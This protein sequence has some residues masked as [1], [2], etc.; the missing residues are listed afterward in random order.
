MSIADYQYPLPDEK[1]ARFP[2]PKR[3]ESKL[4]IYRQG[5]I[6]ERNYHQ[7]PNFIPANALLIL[8]DTRVV[9]ARLYM[10]TSGG[11]TVEVFC[12]EPGAGYADISSAMLTPGK[13]QWLCLIGGAKK[14]KEGILSLT[15]RQGDSNINLQAR[16]L[17]RKEG[18]F[19]L[20]LSWMP[21]SVSF[22]EMLSIVG[23]LP[24]PPYLN[25]AADPEDYERYQTVFAQHQGSVAA[26][27]AG[28]HFTNELLQNLKN[29]S[30]TNAFITLHV[31]AGTFMPVKTEKIGDHE[32]HREYI[33]VSIDFLQTLQQHLPKP[34]ITV[35]TT[36][37][38]TLESIYWLGSKLIQN[39]GVL[40][41]ELQVHQWDPYQPGNQTATPLAAIHALLSWMQQHQLQHLMAT[42]Q[43]MIAP[44]YPF[45]FTDALITN[46]HQPG[47]TLLLLVSALVGDDWRKIYEYALNHS[48]RFLSYGDGSLLWRTNNQ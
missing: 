40:P 29:K 37:M 4:L 11:Q 43:L 12:L 5:E 44:G 13:V 42:T 48:F 1:I 28:L 41:G 15:Y 7:L 34:V 20:E 26:P 2:L 14:W 8:N 24:L 45:Q 21:E 31:G 35:G 25:R 36:S 39:P 19:L 10:Q 47:S 9:P 6:Q 46:F 33:E 23:E 16:L 18:S 27:T 30:I 32:M 17:E 38:R 3:D 22:A